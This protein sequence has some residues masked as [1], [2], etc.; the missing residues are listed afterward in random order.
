MQRKKNTFWAN[1]WAKIFG[2]YPSRRL[3]KVLDYIMYRISD[4]ANLREVTQEEY[5]RR[6][7]SPDEVEKILDNPKLVAAA[8]KA[9]GE[10]FSSGELAPSSRPAIEGQHTPESDTFRS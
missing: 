8:R 10:D 6:N 3:E 4:G 1:F 2:P 9:M 5:V 7:A